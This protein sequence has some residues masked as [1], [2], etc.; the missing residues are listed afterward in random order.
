MN[1]QAIRLLNQQLLSPRFSKP[2]DVVSYMGAMQAQDYRMMR[3]AVAMRTGH[4]SAEAFRKAYDSGEIIRH[5]SLRGTWQ[6]VAGEDYWWM[7]DLCASGAEAVIRGWMKSNRIVIPEEE[8][9]SVCDVFIATVGLKGSVT[10]DDLDEALKEKGFHMDRHRL[11]YHIR[12][13]ELRGILCSGNLTPMKATYS[14]SSGKIPGTSGAI[15]RD[16]ALKKLAQKY[17]QSHSPAS[18]EDFVWWSGMNMSDCRKGMFLLGDSLHRIAWNGKELYIHESCRTGGFRKGRSLLLPPYDE[19]LI[20]Y[21]S[22]EIVI[23][24]ENAHFAYSNNGIFFP[25]I[26]HDGI[27]CGNWKPWDKVLKVSFFDSFEEKT[28]LSRQWEQFKKFRE[29]DKKILSK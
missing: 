19:Y 6:L 11:S 22:R 28:D 9:S 29:L 2:S 23:P 7:Q 4:P 18:L 13:A 21:K 3:W 20:S 15:D 10:S 14:L 16:E 17:F 25:V 12:L 5:H 26:V 27:V 8:Q 24:P 1:L